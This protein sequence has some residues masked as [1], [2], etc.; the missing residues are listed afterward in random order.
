MH[1]TELENEPEDTIQAEASNIALCV[2]S[3]QR[4]C[5][6]DR[7]CCMRSNG[8]CEV[9]LTIFQVPSKEGV[10][11]HETPGGMSRY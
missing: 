4:N 7:T 3:P 6:H 10:H 11:Y 1:V 2:F 8:L 5:D 9:V